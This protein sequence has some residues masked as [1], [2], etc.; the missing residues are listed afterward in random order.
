MFDVSF[1]LDDEQD[2]SSVVGTPSVE[3]LLRG[4][5]NWLGLDLAPGHTGVFIWNDAEDRYITYGFKVP[6]DLPK[7]DYYYARVRRFFNEKFKY[8]FEGM[9]FSRVCVEDV[10]GGENYDTFCQLFNINTVIDDLIL[11][12][13]I[14]CDKLYRVKPST[15]MSGL[16]KVV[17]TKGGFKSKYRTQH[18]LKSIGYKF[19]LD[20]EGKSAGW[21]ADTFYEDICDATGLVIG[22][23]ALEKHDVPIKKQSSVRLSQIE[24][25]FLESYDDIFNFRGGFANNYVVDDVEINKRVIESEIKRLVNEDSGMIYCTNLTNAELGVFGIK[26]GFH[27]SCESG[28]LVFY[29]KE[30]K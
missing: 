1:G 17:Q 18:I 21:L 19:A 28:W 2:V 16:S 14:T 30:L 24:V 23:R 4:T 29:S 27:V 3:L 7:D 10:Y 25:V 20:G 26:R 5:G 8:L 12:G 15:W 22:L 9:H 6:D 11:D 13:V